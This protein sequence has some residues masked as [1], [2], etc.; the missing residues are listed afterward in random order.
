MHARVPTAFSLSVTLHAGVVLVIVTL[1]FLVRQNQQP[2]M[3]IFE[4][5]AGPPTDLTATE[6]PARGIRTVQWK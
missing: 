5:V 2:P 3:Q 1:A 6:A 4:L